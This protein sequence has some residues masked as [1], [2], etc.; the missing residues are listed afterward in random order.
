M[1]RS[2]A[3]LALGVLLATSPSA[4]GAEPYPTKPIRLLVPYAAGGGTDLL[5]RVVGQKLSAVWGQQIVIDN[6]LGDRRHVRQSSRARRGRD[7]ECLEAARL[8]LRPC[9][10]DARERDR[11]LAGEQR[12]HLRPAAL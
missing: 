5:A 2:L 12:G 7:A 6:R 8:E 11:G 10:G 9:R 3:A 1:I 4:R